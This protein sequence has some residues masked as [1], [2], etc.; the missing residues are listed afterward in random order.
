MSILNSQIE[1]HYYH[2]DLYNDIINRLKELNVDLNNVTRK[3]IARVDE[4]HVR[5]VEV[6]RELAKTANINS[7]KVLDIGCGIGGPCRM[8]A[9]EFNCE[10]IGIDISKEYVV[11]AT[12]LSKLVGLGRK[13]KFIHGDATNL[14][15]KNNEFDVV[16]AQHV[17]MNISDKL[18]YYSEIHRVLKNNGVFIYYEVF[19]KGHGEINYPVP[20]ADESK[21]SFLEQ[22]SAMNSILEQLGLTKNL[23]TD[24][25]E[26]G[27]KILEKISVRTSENIVPKLG[28]NLLM[29]AS[30]RNK[31]T[32]LL[33]GLKDGKIHLES[34]V[35]KKQK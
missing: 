21:I 13:T 10:A 26:S 3:D 23:S 5:G 31:T 27:I 14:P 25:T 29:G 24:Q 8:L 33:N 11:T 6:S 20:W 9:D 30:E 16:W 1:E 34:G 18:S 15:F 32:N 2:P 7:S 4:F 35:F 12:K 19:K 22:S 28:L 17:Q